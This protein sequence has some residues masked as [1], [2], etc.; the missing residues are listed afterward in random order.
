MQLSQRQIDDFNEQ[1]FLVLKDC[2]GSS[3]VAEIAAAFERIAERAKRQSHSFTEQGTQ[4]VIEGSRIDRVVWCAGVEAG[5]LKY[6][7]SPALLNPIRQLLES[8]ELVQ[9]ICQAHF[10]F[11]GDGVAFPWH[12][13]SE[14][15]KYGTPLW[16]DING[17]G[18]Y[19]QSVM[20]VDQVTQ[21]NGPLKIVP[22]S[23]KQGHLYLEAAPDKRSAFDRS[24]FVSPDL[25]PGS[26][27]L[28]GPYT[29]HGSDVNQ[30]KTMRR[31]FING[32]ALPG[33]NHFYYPGCG[34]G[35]RVSAA[36]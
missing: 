27:I 20:A 19:I 32:F 12:Q 30:S 16:Q 33:A 7:H 34:T 6:A 2:F 31:V 26:I 36:D 1:G 22:G 9:L 5:L 14:H 17:R 25:S 10:K 3:D 24:S 8:Q 18:S 29:V 13:D 23:Q 15:R 4:F 21:M 35:L 28:F 11:P